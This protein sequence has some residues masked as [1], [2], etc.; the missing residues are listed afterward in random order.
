[1]SPKHRL[2]GLKRRQAVSIT[3]W[4]DHEKRIKGQI[5]EIALGGRSGQPYV[6]CQSSTA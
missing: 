1:M 2:P 3:L 4:A 5:R 6:S